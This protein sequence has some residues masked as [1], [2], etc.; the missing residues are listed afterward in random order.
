MSVGRLLRIARQRV[1]TLFRRS[2]V[3]VELA[4]E[5]S[6]H[7]EQLT[8]E[9]VDAGLSPD[10]ARRAAQRSIGNLPLLEEQCRD[11]RAISW[12]HDVRQ[13]LVYGV[14]LL[15]RNPGFTLVAVLSLA[16]GIGANTAVLSVIDAVLR[17]SLPIPDDGR[18]V[19]L[20]TVPRDNPQQETHALV[21]DYLTWRDETRSFDLMG[22][23]MGH[24]ADF[25]SDISG[26]PPERIGGQLVSPE[27]LV[28]LGVTPIRGRLFAAGEGRGEGAGRPLLISHRLWQRRFAGREDIVGQQLRLDRGLWTIIGVMPERFRYPNEIADYWI[29]LYLDQAQERDP[30]RFYVV[31]A[32]L[33]SGVTV[34]QAQSDLEIVAARLEQRDPDRHEG[35]SVRVK[36]LREAMLGWTRER[37]FTL[38]AAVALVLLVACA[39]LAG[40]LLARGLVRT[41]EVALR[42]ALGA[43]RG[44][45]VRQLLTESIVLC[46]AGGTLGLFVAWAGIHALT[47]MRPPPGGVAMD[48]VPLS[49][50]TFVVTA[51]ISIATGLL[52][53]LTPV[54][55]QAMAPMADR[56]KES[57]GGRRGRPRVRNALVA[58]QIAVTVVLL[59]GAGL[60]MQSFARV[61]ARDLHFDSDRLLTFELNVPLGDY[62]QRRGTVGGLPY[63]EIGPSPALAFERVSRGLLTLPNVESVAGSSVGLINS[64]V[65]PAVTISRDPIPA[66]SPLDPPPSLAIGV[67]TAM[68]LTYRRPLTAAYFLVTPSFFTSLKTPLVG[69][70]DVSESD[71]GAARWVA[72][73]NEAA[74]RRFWPGENPIGRQFTI[75]NSPEER[76]RDVIGIVRD[77]PMTLE[78]EV[79]PAIYTSYLQ[80]PSH[81]PNPGANMFGHM[82]FMVRSTGDP[83]RL[84]PGVRRVVDSVDPERPLV[85]VATMDQRLASVVPTRGYVTVGVSAFALT[86]MLL[87]AIGIYGVMA[88]AVAQRTREIGIR[89]ALGAAAHEIVAAVGQRTFVVVSL[90]LGT[91]L[92]GAFGAARLIQSQLWGVTAGDPLTFAAVSLL[93]LVVALVAAFVPMRRAMSINPTIALRCE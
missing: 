76:P 17:D 72:I 57:D 64:L 4:R 56:L 33:K 46:V 71:A 23:A 87:A 68:H 86:A 51:L 63:F 74:A 22:V 47:G 41:P 13:D 89:M 28:A 27:T 29:P 16:L 48:S 15:R 44:R 54:L 79:R 19:V 12:I 24:N 26:A 93:L 60:L 2:D 50:R 35:W 65:I 21:A 32:R 62:L 11:T 67:G 14:R 66:P 20:R 73:I 1:R 55:A 10:D 3:D 70:R 31:T 8:Q 49:L 81:Y 6:F 92:L 90:G 85:N 9:F 91:G 39:N 83:M 78:G 53:G 38:E 88:Y 7:L 82:M 5:L 45:I 18:L 30:Q 84:V 58:L 75:L 37:L 42:T 61:A 59:V 34:E 25:G 80:Q 36:P 69:G 40:L 43:G 77:I 52:Y